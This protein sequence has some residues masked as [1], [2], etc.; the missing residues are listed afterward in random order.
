M[1]VGLVIVS[2]SARLAAGVVEL[3]RE[4]AGAEVLIEAAGG[5]DE[6]GDPIGTDA[7]RVMGAIERVTGD[8]GQ[9]LVLMDLGSAVLSAELALDLLDPAV[10]ER[11]LLCEA[12]LVEGAVAAAAAARAGGSL[13]DAAREARNGL[14]GKA[15]HLGADFEESPEVDGHDDEEGWSAIEAT[16]RTAHGL[17]ARP[18]AAVVRAAADHD[19]Q[20]RVRNLTTGA[21]PANARSLTALSMLGALEDHRVLIEARGPNAARALTAVRAIISERTDDV[22]APIDVAVAAPVRVPEPGEELRGVPAAPGLGSGPALVAGGVATPDKPSGDPTS[23]RAA[24]GDARAAA[25]MEL[26][27][28]RAAAAPVVGEII[29]AQ[30]LVLDDDAVVDAAERAIT[31]GTGAARAWHDATRAAAQGYQHLDDPY[32]RARGADV[33]DVGRRVVAL[34][35]GDSGAESTSG[36]L[37]ADELGAAEVAALDVA[38]TTAIVM[39]GGGATS[40]ASI[41][42]RSRGIPAVIGLGGGLLA[43]AAGTPLLVDGD[44]GVVVVAPTPEAIERH[45]ARARDALNRAKRAA[46]HAHESAITTDG[47][48]IEV[49]ANIGA[50]GDLEHAVAG[51][52][53]GVGLLRS[54]FLFLDRADAP[55]EDEQYDAY[56]DAVQQMQGRRVVL[57]TLDAGADKPMAYLPLAKEENPFLGVRGIRLCLEQPRLFVAQLRAALRVAAEAPLALM[58]PMISELAELRAARDMLETARAELLAEGLPAGQVEVGAMVEVPAAAV[59]ADV[60]AAEVDFLSIGTNDLTQY[61][62]AAERGNPRVAALSDALHPAVLRLISGIATAAARHDCRVAV[63]GEMASDPLGVPLLVGLGVDEL[64]VS[65]RR[66]GLVKEAV[67]AVDSA[68]A[69]DLVRGAL[70]LPDAASVRRLLNS[71]EADV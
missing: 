17:H 33:L 27:V 47:I 67:R 56:R 54:E 40:H 57:R 3:A 10:R 43:I 16:V 63:C 14:A 60:L 28:L 45:E 36:V 53:D 52:A 51:G 49:A 6:P 65:P 37:V 23:E 58:F 55:R 20:M 7:V 64:S 39:A 35:T 22:A 15:A 38:Y 46:A 8:G 34:L 50:P 4:M 1:T 42:A 48:T 25:A 61:V 13:D 59:L 70:A 31:Q 66:V 11:V 24:L 21:G 32:L 29:G 69:R 62:M 18:A 9:A 44:T 41:I 26:E 71:R 5:L 19:V 2:H 12:P 30:L 68:A